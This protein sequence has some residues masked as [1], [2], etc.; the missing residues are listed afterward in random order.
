LLFEP[1]VRPQVCGLSVSIVNPIAMI[2]SAYDA[3]SRKCETN[4]SPHQKAI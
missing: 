2:E 3:G 4:L 1:M